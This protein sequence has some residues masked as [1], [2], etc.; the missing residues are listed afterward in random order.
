MRVDGHGDVEAGVDDP[1]E[2]VAL[3]LED[4]ERDE[5]GERERRVVV[6]LLELRGV[7]GVG[8][9]CFFCFLFLFVCFVV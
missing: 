4:G 7:G 1:R 2:D 9:S 5:A 3:L 6:E 8:C